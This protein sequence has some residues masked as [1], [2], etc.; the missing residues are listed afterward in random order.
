MNRKLPGNAAETTVVPYEIQCIRSLL[1]AVLSRAILDYLGQHTR[2]ARAARGWFFGR[3]SINDPL[4]FLFVCEELGYS[5]KRI[6]DYLITQATISPSQRGKPGTTV[7]RLH[8][9]PTRLSHA[10]DHKKFSPKSLRRG[11]VV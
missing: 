11:A 8:T 5:S 1:T 6:R 7:Y 9:G 10:A 3:Q 4:S 2:D